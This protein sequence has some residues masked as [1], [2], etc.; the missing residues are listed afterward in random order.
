MQIIYLLNFF[1]IVLKEQSNETLIDKILF[2][3]YNKFNIILTMEKIKIIFKRRV[4]I[5]K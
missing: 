2:N 1:E 4:S 5:N 3:N